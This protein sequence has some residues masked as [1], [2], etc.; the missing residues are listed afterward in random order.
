VSKKKK[1]QRQQEQGGPP[2]PA[3]TPG[4]PAAEPAVPL[5]A[6]RAQVRVRA[7]VKDPDNPDMPIGG[8]CGTIVEVD[9]ASQP[10]GYLI[11]WDQRTLGH[12]H[13]VFIK[14]CQRDGLEVDN[15]WLD[16]SDLEVD[17]GELLPIEQPT[18]LTTP[19]LDS[20]NQD[21]R[22]R[23][24]FGLT[25]DDALPPA[26]DNTLAG[27]HAFLSSRLTFPFEATIVE[28]TEP[29]QFREARVTV[30]ELLPLD[31]CDADEGLLCEVRLPDNEDGVVPL[32]ELEGLG[33]AELTQLVGDYAYW[34][35]NHSN[36]PD[37]IPFPGDRP[38]G[39][40]G[41][42][43]VPRSFW[44]WLNRFALAGAA[45]GATVGAIATVREEARLGMGIGASVLGLLLAF[46][47]W[48][49]GAIV[50][51]SQGMPNAPVVGALLG[52][53]AGGVF[54]VLAGALA[55]ASI[56]SIPGSI[57]GVLLV[58]A[59][60]S[61]GWRAPSKFLAGLGGAAIGGVMFAF[62]T[63]RQQAVWGLLI[64]TIA[65]AVGAAI[66]VFAAVVTLGVL[67]N[68]RGP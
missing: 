14:R 32:S 9:A 60:A 41:E 2:A 6:L 47:G 54:G 11:R 8:W 5:L 67:M 20:G 19:A 38:E 51:A 36:E 62:Y 17:H 48:R 28:E 40:P 4:T 35:V 66:L 27:Y 46:A 52:V 43:G 44:R 59:V 13:P 49:Y 15:M 23:A 30:R 50:G 1:K 33:S 58:G 22:V 63:D 3:A 25:A 16:E 29:L 10:C 31:E 55:V 34:Y 42:G 61:A 39:L 53:L 18:A 7:G 26:N 68:R 37:V 24:V 45:Y 65:G 56:G 21:D 12:M 57:V 64:G